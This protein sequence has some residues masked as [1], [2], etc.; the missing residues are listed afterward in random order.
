MIGYT[1]N[2]LGAIV[3]YRSIVLSLLIVPMAAKIDWARV[4]RLF[5]GNIK[6]K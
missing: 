3:R 4:N 6:N 2:I 5:F 1:V